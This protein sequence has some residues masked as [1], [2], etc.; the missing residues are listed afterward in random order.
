M[1]SSFQLRIVTPTRQ[2]LDQPVRE[3]SAPGSLGE[4]GVL[5]DHTTFLSSL[6]AGPL[7]FH[8][9]GGSR[10]VAVRGGFAEVSNNVMTVLA[11]DAVF[12][13]DINAAAARQELQEAEAQLE[14]L[15]PNDEAFAAADAKRIWARAKVDAAR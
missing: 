2:L 5:P 4:F 1:A 15:S 10:K 11:D 12:A 7:V 3:V 6:E 9:D 8:A 14:G 13:D